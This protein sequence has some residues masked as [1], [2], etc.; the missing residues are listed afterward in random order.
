MI[1]EK[2]NM[3]GGRPIGGGGWGCVFYPSIQ[4]QSFRREQRGYVSKVMTVSEYN[5]EVTKLRRVRDNLTRIFGSEVNTYFSIQF[6]EAGQPTNFTRED[7][8][9]LRDICKS[10]LAD[11]IETRNFTLLRVLNLPHEGLSLLKYF[12]NSQLA[13]PAP[14]FESLVGRLSVGLEQLLLQGILRMNYNGVFHCD[15]KADNIMQQQSL[16]PIQPKLIDWGLANLPCVTAVRFNQLFNYQT[17]YSFNLPIGFCIMNQPVINAINREFST[18]DLSNNN[19]LEETVLR[20]VIDNYL[21]ARGNFIRET[22]H[23]RSVQAELIRNG[24]N[25]QRMNESW[26]LVQMRTLNNAQLDSIFSASSFR[27][28]ARDNGLNESF[29][30]ALCVNFA[31]FIT[32]F[33]ETSRRSFNWERARD[34]LRQTIDIFGLFSCYLE[35][36]LPSLPSNSTVRERIIYILQNLYFNPLLSYSLTPQMVQTELRQIRDASN[37]Q[38]QRQIAIG[39]A[40]VAAPLPRAHQ[41]T[42]SF[43]GLGSTRPAGGPQPARRQ[44]APQ[45]VTGS[46]IGQGTVNL[47]RGLDRA[48]D[49]HQ[50][51]ETRRR[52][53]LGRA[54]DSH[55]VAQ[56]RG[57]G[58]DGNGTLRRLLQ[59]QQQ[60]QQRAQVVPPDPVA[61]RRRRRRPQV[62]Q[63]APPQLPPPPQPRIQRPQIVQPAPIRPQQQQQGAPVV[64]PPQQQQQGAPVV[65]PAPIRVVR[66]R[67]TRDSAFTRRA[68]GIP[69]QPDINNPGGEWFDPIEGRYKSDLQDYRDNYSSTLNP[70]EYF[71]VK[72][73]RDISRRDVQDAIRH[74]RREGV[75]GEEFNH[76]RRILNEGNYQKTPMAQYTYESTL[77]SD[78]ELHAKYLRERL[79]RSDIG[80][81]TA[82]DALIQG[83][84]DQEAMRLI[85]ENKVDKTPIGIQESLQKVA[86]DPKAFLT[87]AQ[88]AIERTYLGKGGKKTKKMKKNKKKTRKMKKKT[89]H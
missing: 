51:A 25:E 18:R 41:M 27:R 74:A 3:K 44:Q 47:V 86:R 10:Q 30:K 60:Q 20:W 82:N 66:P 87:K 56:T 1:L 80:R 36:S 55:Q 49:S 8:V 62:V 29:Y 9:N 84:S 42:G 68:L 45:P 22:F 79:G 73:G 34:A 50:V 33:Y 15:I 88:K 75:R 52:G 14:D 40:Q 76:I 16:N 71:S 78:P 21:N 26:A 23:E 64:Q 28:R 89:K 12:N 17:N 5:E 38:R 39:R 7:L 72:T 61:D 85:R 32:E 31:M 24:F 11:I 70:A 4:T 6:E 81:R 19:V 77:H 63:P 35:V 48:R 46:F 54:R 59:Q 67:T 65:Q 13:L 43:V 83:D 57:I 53:R 37:P 58:R 69:E 2:N